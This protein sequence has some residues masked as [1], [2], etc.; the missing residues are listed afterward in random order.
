M[1]I[2]MMEARGCTRSLVCHA[3]S[4]RAALAQGARCAADRV[5]RALRAGPGGQR[6]GC[7]SPLLRSMLNNL[8]QPNELSAALEGLHAGSLSRT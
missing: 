8:S 2:N 5:V 4:E 3:Q 6:R 7:H 1:N